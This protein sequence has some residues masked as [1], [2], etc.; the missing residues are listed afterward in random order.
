[1]AKII[2]EENFTKQMEGRP[3]EDRMNSPKKDRK[4]FIREYLKGKQMKA[5]V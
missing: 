2:H 3:I 1:L 4:I 5:T